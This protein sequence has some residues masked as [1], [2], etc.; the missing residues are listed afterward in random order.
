MA[1]RPSAVIR[2]T[3][4]P[5]P[6]VLVQNGA[7]W[8]TDFMSWRLNRIGNAPRHYAHDEIRRA[9]R[10]ETHAKCAYCESRIND[11]S[12]DHIEHKLPKSKFPELVCTWTNLTIACPK[13]NTNKGD[14]DNSICP[15]LD[16]YV[17]DVEH[18][19][20]FGGPLALP[21]GG[22]RAS[23]TINLLDLNRM[24]LLY[25][26]GQTLTN[27]N[28]LLDMID[29]AAGQSELIESLWIEIDRLLG[30]KEEF[31]SACRQFVAWQITERGLART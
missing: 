7:R 4:A 24:E 14:F 18:E 23:A 10:D 1:M 19:V 17:D 9:L 8:K 2:L 29:R 12:Y 5:E 22:P 11:V 30:E 26:R 21:R 20:A 16:P 13:C 6:H 25:S 3:K 27:I 31:A 28:R 15:L